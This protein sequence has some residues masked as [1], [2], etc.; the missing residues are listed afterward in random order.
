MEERVRTGHPEGSA[1]PTGTGAGSGVRV[2]LSRKKHREALE[3][4]VK[5]CKASAGAVPGRVDS[6]APRAAASVPGSG[7]THRGLTRTLLLLPLATARTSPLNSSTPT[8]S[9]AFATTPTATT[10]AAAAT[11]TTATTAATTVASNA[12][13]PHRRLQRLHSHHHSHC[14]HRHLH[15]LHRPHHRLHHCHPH[16]PDLP[17]PCRCGASH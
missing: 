17:C 5:V 14:H 10:T 13:T 2:V 9:T 6:L 15:H 7:G 4:G 8:A 11:P 3:S 1:N 12:S 16:H